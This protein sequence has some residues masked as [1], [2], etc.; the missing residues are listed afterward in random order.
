MLA[1]KIAYILSGDWGQADRDQTIC[2]D[3]YERIAGSYKIRG[4]ME[5]IGMG[6]DVVGHRNR[7]PIGVLCPFRTPVDSLGTSEAFGYTGGLLVPVNSRV[8]D[9][10]K[11][12]NLYKGTGVYPGVQLQF[13]G[14][15]PQF[16]VN[17]PSWPCWAGEMISDGAKSF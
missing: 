10:A 6:K 11:L 8:T 7:R 9:V 14:L 3:K 17:L 13:A 5:R 12:F 16:M 2:E 1:G 4:L 15:C